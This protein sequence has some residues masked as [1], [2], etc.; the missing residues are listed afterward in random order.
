MSDFI[1]FT[2]PIY[3]TNDVPHIGHAY[4]S[5]V[6]DVMSRS[7]RMINWRVKFCTGVDENSQKALMKAQELNMEIYDYL[8]I[9]ASKHRLV[10][11]SLKISYTDFIRTTEDRHRIYVQNILQQTYDI[12]DIYKWVYE[13]LYCTGCEGFKKNSDLTAEWLCPDHLK[14][15]TVVK[16]HNRF[17]KLSSYQASLE[18][19]YIDHADFVLPESRF[20]EVKAFVKWGLEDFSISR[21]TVAFGIPLP[22]DNTQ[23]TYVRYDALLNYLTVCQWWDEFFA[24]HMVHV[25][26]KDITRFHA[27][28]RPAM[29]MSIMKSNPKIGNILPKHIISTGFLTVNGTKISKSLGNAINPVDL[30][31]IYGR[32]ALVLYLLYDLKLGSD[33][34]F[35]HTRFTDMYQSMLVGW[36]WNLVNR[37]C[38]LAIKYNIQVATID[39]SMRNILVEISQSM[40]LQN[41]IISMILTD[42]DVATILQYLQLW[43]LN[44]YVIDRYQAVQLCNKFV[45]EL[46]PWSTLKWWDI[47]GTQCI[48]A[49]LHII[50]QINV[51]SASLFLDGHI[52]VCANLGVLTIDTSTGV[53]N[54]IPLLNQKIIVLNINPTLVYQ[55]IWK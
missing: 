18:S 28:Y 4:S 27:I 48:Q 39:D 29:L 22:W 11:D 7:Y 35:S 33:W 10:W 46:K 32:D 36:W 23:V 40:G 30:V 45:D 1:F 17:F 55:P 12:E 37:V 15:P 3:Y 8:D 21:Q 50:Y 44:Q 34:D 51:L 41:P 2:T 42:S 20:A 53:H 43:N 31:D 16:E 19:L 52:N 38:T 5:I 26:A 47:Q 24:H 6:A 14:I 9:M 54:I 13:W 25:M 49:L